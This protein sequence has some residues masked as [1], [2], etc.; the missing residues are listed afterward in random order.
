MNAPGGS[1][2]PTPPVCIVDDDPA[3]LRAVSWLLAAEGYATLT[4]LASQD[5][6]HHLDNHAVQVA[7]LDVW[8]DGMSGLDLLLHLKTRSPETR[9]IMMTA[10]TDAGTKSRADAAGVH[11]YFIKPF[12]VELFMASVAA[13]LPAR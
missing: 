12:D 2:D 7:V 1:P 3:V 10:A 9:V 11:G 6:L 8:M 5:F 4:F 13:A